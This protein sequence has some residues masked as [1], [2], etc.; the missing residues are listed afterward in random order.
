M[1]RKRIITCPFIKTCNL[2]VTKE[3]YQT[4]CRVGTRL[5]QTTYQHCYKYRLLTI[6]QNERKKPNEWNSCEQEKG[7]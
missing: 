4:F 3:H 1:F 2:N 5:P 6:E 7:Q